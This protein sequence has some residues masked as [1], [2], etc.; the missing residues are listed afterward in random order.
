MKTGTRPSVI[1]SKPAINDHF[2]TANEAEPKTPRPGWSRTPRTIDLMLADGHLTRPLFVSR[3][4]RIDAL[5]LATRQQ[6]G[7]WHQ[8]NQA[9]QVVGPERFMEMTEKRQLFDFWFFGRDTIGAWPSQKAA[10]G[11]K[12]PK[13]CNLEIESCRPVID[14]VESRKLKWKSWFESG[15]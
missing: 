13:D 7:R 10:F 2:K 11:K 8:Q 14:S 4:G 5:G 3:V 12:A 15:R 9:D 1:T 6:E